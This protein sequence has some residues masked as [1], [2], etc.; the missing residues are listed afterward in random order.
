[1]V[2][3]FALVAKYQERR[4][5][6]DFS[7][8]PNA[9]RFPELAPAKPTEPKDV[10]VKT[11]LDELFSDWK[12]LHQANGKA[13]RTV[14]DYRQKWASLV[15]YSNVTD[16][17]AITKATIRSW[18]ASLMHPEP[19]GGQAPLSPRTVRMKYLA[20]A[21]A[22]YAVAVNNGKIAENPAS[23]YAPKVA[24]PKRERPQGFTDDEAATILSAS[25]T[26]LESLGRMSSENK[27]GVRWIPWV[28]AFTGARVGEVAQLRKE[29]FREEKDISY[30]RITPEA[31]AVKGRRYRDIPLHPQLVQEGLL[32]FVRSH[33]PGYLFFSAKTPEDAIKKAN[34]VAG[35]V[36]QWVRNDVQITDDRISPSHA[37]RHRFKTECI[38]SDVPPDYAEVL[39][40]HEDGRA[41]R[42][43]GDYPIA[44]LARE[45]GKLPF[46]HLSK[47]E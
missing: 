32:A 19:G 1:M 2:D 21:K 40:G 24:K 18:C 36:S 6:G 39:M 22:I 47:D 34:S 7:P 41:A 38:R 13:E 29:D 3:A 44:A 4:A 28:C 31:G 33:A 26:A 9:N 8:D 16:P 11:T 10:T 30:L 20:A 25:R 5:E 45:I 37:W 23:G 17:E 46:L 27:L 15:S 14:T 12:L 42:G 43:Y 35:K